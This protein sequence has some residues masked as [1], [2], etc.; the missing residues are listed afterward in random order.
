MVRRFDDR[1]LRIINNA[2]DSSFVSLVS[3]IVSGFMK[4]QVADW[5]ESMPKSWIHK[6]NIHLRTK[7]TWSCVGL[8]MMNIGMCWSS[9][10]K[11]YWWQG[12]VL[13]V[14]VQRAIIH[15]SL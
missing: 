10:Y 5:R 13:S 7:T 11:V 4:M 9:S 3:G 2:A 1:L 15:K 6:I 8:V 14:F 12:V